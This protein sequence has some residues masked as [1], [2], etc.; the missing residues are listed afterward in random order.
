MSKPRTNLSS[1]IKSKYILPAL[2]ALMLAAASSHSYACGA[3]LGCFVFQKPSQKPSQNYKYGDTRWISNNTGIPYGWAIIQK[4]SG[5]RLIKNLN[6]A[7]YPAKVTV[8]ADSPYPSGWVLRPGSNNQTKS[9]IYIA[10]APS[11]AKVD[12]A[13]GAA[14]P[15]NWADLLL[16]GL[17]NNPV[18]YQTIRNL[19]GN[20]F[21]RGEGVIV[22]KSSN[23]PSGWKVV[24]GSSLS[25]KILEKI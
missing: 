20:A 4:Q 2:T 5:N 1:T 15:N 6:G 18:N 3:V 13:K 19:S 22:T 21:S 14:Y 25:Y 23:V 17:G 12:I 11:G 8:T 7:K 16:R 10:D 24:S 9:L